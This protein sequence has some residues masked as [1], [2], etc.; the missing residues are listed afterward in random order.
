MYGDLETIQDYW[1]SLTYDVTAA[2]KKIS[3]RP[4]FLYAAHLAAGSGG[5]ATAIIRDG[6]ET[7]ADA[8][9][10]L[11]ALTSSIDVRNFDPPLYFKKGLYVDVGSNVTSVLVSFMTV[12]EKKE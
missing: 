11:A 1:K 8:V 7:S 9:I 4:C 2:D 12:R 6:T 5:A 10:T 3:G